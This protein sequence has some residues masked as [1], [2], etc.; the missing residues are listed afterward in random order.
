MNA[1]AVMA[2]TESET[3]RDLYER[4]QRVPEDE[5]AFADSLR[6][7]RVSEAEIER[8]V[9][10]RFEYAHY[11]YVALVRPIAKSLEQSGRFARVEVLGPFGLSARV[12]MNAYRKEGDDKPAASAYFCPD[13]SFEEGESCLQWVDVCGDNGEYAPGTLGHLNGFHYP[14]MPIPMDTRID[15][16]DYWVGL[17]Y[18]RE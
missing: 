17:M 6:D 16:V 7:Q 14:T 3:L 4:W 15:D 2:E 10:A 1:D 8:A 5:Q 12:S 13:L 11:W 9:K 18:H